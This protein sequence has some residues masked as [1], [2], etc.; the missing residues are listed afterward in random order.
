MART[1]QYETVTD[2]QTQ[3][4]YEMTLLVRA[5]ANFPHAVV[6]QLGNTA[7]VSVPERKGDVINWR[8]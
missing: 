1:H 5:V 3:Y 6:A 8:S 7:K 2:E 4:F